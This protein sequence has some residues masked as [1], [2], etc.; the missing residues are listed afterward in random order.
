LTVI[1]TVILPILIKKN[2]RGWAFGAY[3]GGE[4]CAQGVGGE[5]S[6]KETTVETQT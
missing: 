2:E 5:A 1:L 4:R 6:G 3:G